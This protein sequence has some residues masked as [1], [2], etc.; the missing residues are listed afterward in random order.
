VSL[1]HS[2]G[3]VHGPVSAE[4]CLTP[5]AWRTSFVIGPRPPP[6][7]RCA[8]RGAWLPDGRTGPTMTHS[9]SG[10]PYG[11]PA[12][13]GTLAR[14]GCSPALNPGADRT[15]PNCSVD[16]RI[17]CWVRF[18]PN[19]HEAGRSP[20]R[21]LV[22]H[23]FE[24][25]RFVRLPVGRSTRAEARGS[26]HR[27]GSLWNHPL[28][29]ISRETSEYSRGRETPAGPYSRKDGAIHPGI[30]AQGLAYPRIVPRRRIH[31][32]WLDATRDPGR[33]R[34]SSRGSRFLVWTTIS[35]GAR[36]THIL[37]RRPGMGRS[38]CG[39]SSSPVD[40]IVRSFGSNTGPSGAYPGSGLDHE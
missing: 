29:N 12:L 19:R 7:F 3:V 8:G 13:V 4:G 35:P 24:A 9:R 5:R 40:G 30:Q 39:R 23:P 17:E 18:R 26:V 16:T 38:M 11:P 28:T 10:R 31:C 1:V 6:A 36:R 21:K 33:V 2:T 32:A 37:R 15:A 34:C 27:R 25:S 22:R 20:E 14:A